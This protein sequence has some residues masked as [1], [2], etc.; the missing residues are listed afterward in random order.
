MHIAW[1]LSEGFPAAGEMQRIAENAGVGL[2]ALE[3]G[4]A[5]RYGCARCG[6]R[7][8]L[9]GYS[10]V[11]EV[12]IEDGIARLAKALVATET[13]NNGVATARPDTAPAEPAPGVPRPST[14]C[15]C[16]AGLGHFSVRA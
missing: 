7:V 16:R 11:S 8:L 13:G 6:Q 9:L 12:Q 4:A 15:A 1:Y 5:Y 3:S 14:A 10:S 2:Y